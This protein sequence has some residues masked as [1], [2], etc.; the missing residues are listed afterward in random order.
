[1]SRRISLSRLKSASPGER[2]ELLSGLVRGAR[3]PVNG[4]AG[5]LDD[6]I[7]EYERRYEMPSDEMAERVNNGTL[8]ETDDIASWLMALKV[9]ARVKAD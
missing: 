6:R 8:Q 5:K 4:Y 3:Q 2:D 1:M 9:K 7:A